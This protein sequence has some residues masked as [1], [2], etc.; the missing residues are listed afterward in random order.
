MTQADS[1]MMRES[2]HDVSRRTC[3][4]VPCRIAGGR[5][6]RCK[7]FPALTALRTL[8]ILPWENR[9]VCTRQC[10]ANDWLCIM[11]NLLFKRFDH[12]RRASHLDTTLSG[13]KPNPAAHDND[14]IK[15][16]DADDW[17][18]DFHDPLLVVFLSRS[19]LNPKQRR[20]LTSHLPQWLNLTADIIE[21]IPLLFL[22]LL[23]NSLTN[24]VV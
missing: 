22:Q 21:L 24:R 6:V 23:I 10:M 15:D 14:R 7:I 1:E 17:A 8:T 18:Y 12:G 13:S 16:E 9:I 19:P 4:P 20:S 11:M 5:L 3:S 2:G